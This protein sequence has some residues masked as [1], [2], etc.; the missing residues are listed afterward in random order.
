[1]LEKANN[2]KNN[3][4][5][6]IENKGYELLIEKKE[7]E[8]KYS[9]KEEYFVSSYDIKCE[10]HLKIQKLIPLVKNNFKYCI[11]IILNVMTIIHYLINC[12]SPILK[13]TNL[14]F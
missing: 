4:L 1:M 9:E 13:K 7:N 3:D 12:P 14:S 8:K 5:E 6:L 11:Y 2:S 10:E